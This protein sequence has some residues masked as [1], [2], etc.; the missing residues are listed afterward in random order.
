MVAVLTTEEPD[1]ETGPKIITDYDISHIEVDQQAL[2]YYR[3]NGAGT[4]HDAFSI[5][6]ILHTN[7]CVK[8]A[9]SVYGLAFR[10]HS[11]S[12]EVYPLPHSLLQARLLC[13]LKSGASPSEREINLL[14]SLNIPVAHYIEGVEQAWLAH[15]Y[16][17]AVAT[18]GNAYEEFHTGEEIDSIFLEIAMNSSLDLFSAKPGAVSGR[19]PRLLFMYWDQNPPPEISDNFAYHQ[20]IDGFECRI[21]DKHEAAE[22]LYDNYGIEART[23]FLGARHP[24]EAADFLRVHVTQFYG[25]WW[26]DADIRIRNKDAADFM[27][28]RTDQNV[29]V[30]THNYVV[31][32][33]FY[34]TIPNS[35]MGAD[36]LLSLYRNC[37]QHGGLFI[38]Y[39]TGPGIFNRALSRR[40]HRA[41][42]GVTFPD[43][44]G[45]YKNDM[46]DRLIYQFDTPYKSI[47]PSW[48]SV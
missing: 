15:D 20:N 34:G 39:K 14:R 9:A 12:A 23:L 35:S 26:L 13:L 37:Y 43:S 32:N 28:S 17:S 6:N 29:V 2:D 24:A 16:N 42:E 27:A 48:H 30:L 7:R 11:E 33:D 45:I 25:G 41:C 1:I 38:A 3:R 22:W 18:I 8:E 4:L 19:I 5:A 46:F 44:I 36:C 47:L 21:F 10:L 31:H 40:I